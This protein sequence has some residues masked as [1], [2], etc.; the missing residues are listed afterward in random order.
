MFVESHQAL[1]LTFMLGKSHPALELR[2]HLFLGESHLAIEIEV[3]FM[4]R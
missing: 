3:R 2:L 4:F 1:E